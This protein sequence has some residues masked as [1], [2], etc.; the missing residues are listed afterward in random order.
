MDTKRA[1]TEAGKRQFEKFLEAIADGMAADDAARVTGMRSLRAAIAH[2]DDAALY[3]IATRKAEALWTA[4]E[5]WLSALEDVAG[6]M[7]DRMLRLADDPSTPAHIRADLMK[8]VH[9]E[10]KE[11]MQQAF[12]DAVARQA[13]ADAREARAAVAA[14][15]IAPG[16]SSPRLVDLRA[17][18]MAELDTLETK[19]T[20]QVARLSGE[21]AVISESPDIASFG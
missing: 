3:R 10:T 8:Y 14:P 15:A 12:A 20:R 13:A 9:A 5:Q 6:G 4:Y 7:I 2:I 19:L 17:L 1:M 21:E 16:D 11:A 18:S